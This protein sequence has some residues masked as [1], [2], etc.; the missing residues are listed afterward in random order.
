[1]FK[2]V[3]LWRSLSAPI[4]SSIIFIIASFLSQGISFITTPIFTRLLTTE[5]YGI[6]S[7]YNSWYSILSVVVLLSL[8]SAGAFNVGIHKYND[9]KYNYISSLLFLTTASSVIFFMG[10][11]IFKPFFSLMLNL[12]DSLIILMM[13]SFILL[14]ATNFWLSKQRYEYKYKSAAL[15]IFVSTILSQIISII[16]VLSSDE[17]LAVVRLWSSSSV[18]LLVGGIFYILFFIRGK[19]FVNK[20][21]W[22]FTL[23]F[24]IPLIPHYLASNLLINA[25]KIMID[26]M[27]NKRAAGIY[28]IVYTLSMIGSIIWTS[29]NGSLVPY[30]FDKLDN[31]EYNDINNISKN[32]IKIYFVFCLLIVLFAPEIM[33]ILAPSDYYEGVYIMPTVA[34]GILLSAIYNLY[35]NVEFYFKK[36]LGIAIASVI[37]AL[38]NV[39][40]N[41]FLIPKFGYYIAGYTT[42]VSY[43]LL[44]FF[45]YINV[46]MIKYDNIYD[47]KFMFKISLFTMILYS[48]IPTIYNLTLVRYTVIISIIIYLSFKI[49]YIKNTLTSLKGKN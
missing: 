36:S 11:V 39:I 28:S 9:D 7:V 8:N 17:N 32:I 1:M 20:S 19:K 29:I 31:K 12:P 6:I 18:T 34:A 37:A 46:R 13:L 15:I 22:K 16:A 35:G 14:P 23:K 2:K 45:H 42:M 27:V 43:A 40:L 25:D 24:A 4:K 21:Y 26:V 30:T 10:Y 5:D 47:S 38:I 3:F 49:S 33:R 44:A 48:F 41:Y